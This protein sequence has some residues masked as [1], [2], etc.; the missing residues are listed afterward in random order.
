MTFS[1]KY[2]FDVYVCMLCM[3]VC[4]FVC[5]YVCMYICMYVCMYV[6]DGMGWD[7]CVYGMF[8][9]QVLRNHDFAAEW[10]ISTKAKFFRMISKS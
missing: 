4:M 2:F 7:V 9:F 8:A 10:F 6:C 5:M 3:Y 1:K